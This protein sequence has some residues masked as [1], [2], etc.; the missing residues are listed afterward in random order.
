MCA[1]LVP[2]PGDSERRH[3]S[4]PITETGGKNRAGFP[5][6]LKSFF[7]DD[8]FHDRPEQMFTALENASDDDPFD[9]QQIDQ[10]RDPQSELGGAFF[11]HLLC[12]RVVRI[13]KGAYLFAERSCPV[14]ILYKPLMPHPLQ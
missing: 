12:R 10:E 1:P 3:V 9:I 4:K 7:F 6:C 5:A 8:L 14:A 13:G 11:E 2:V